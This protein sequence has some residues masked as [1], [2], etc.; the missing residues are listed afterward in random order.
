MVRVHVPVIDPVGG[1]P[2]WETGSVGFAVRRFLVVRHGET[3]WN[4]MGRRQGQLDSPLTEDGWRH[5]ESVADLCVVLDADAVF[6]SP[7]GRARA[8][9]DVVGS[10]LSLPVAS[11]QRSRRDRPRHVR[12]A[13]QRGDRGVSSR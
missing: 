13:H 12:G 1:V 4:R 2:D 6:S 10:R 3:E 5:A 7:L 11:H 8:T 9:A